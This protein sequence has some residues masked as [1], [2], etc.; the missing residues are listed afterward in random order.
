MF[1][2]AVT[3]PPLE[4]VVKLN[5][6]VLFSSKQKFPEAELPSSQTGQADIVASK[7]LEFIG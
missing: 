5:Q 4:L 2:S 7:L 3:V 1:I 6:T